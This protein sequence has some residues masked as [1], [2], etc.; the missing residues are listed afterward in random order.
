MKRPTFFK[1]GEPTEE[2][3]NEIESW[4]IDNRESFKL[5][6]EYVKEC[7][8]THYGRFE[9]NS[10]YNKLSAFGEDPFY[11]L[12]IATGGWS[13]N[14]VIV[15]S[16]NRNIYVQARM[17]K[18]SVSGGLYIYKIPKFYLDPNTDSV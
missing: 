6:I 12:E 16:I 17:F 11:A 13:E 18:A 15:R 14:E 3:L 9:F 4:V 10:V 5:F 2:T 7:F 8:D 1:G